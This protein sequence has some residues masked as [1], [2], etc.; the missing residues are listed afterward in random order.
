MEISNCR[1]PLRRTNQITDS[2]TGNAE[3]LRKTGNRNCP[4]GHS[5]Q[6]RWANVLMAVVE[7]VLVNFICYDEQI[8]TDCDFRNCLQFPPIE[9]LARRVS[10][11]I[12]HNSPRTRRDRA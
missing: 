11:R 9:D 2:P 10:W 4:L 8:V 7:K 3:R 12:D 5:W 6:R 1:S